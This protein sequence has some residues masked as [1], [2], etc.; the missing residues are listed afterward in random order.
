MKVVGNEIIFTEEEK[1]RIN[2][3]LEEG[4][5]IQRQNGNKLYTDEEVWKPIL[6]EKYYNELIQE[7]MWGRNRREVL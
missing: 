7:E 4:E 5:E 3:L 1:E 2:Y 6:G